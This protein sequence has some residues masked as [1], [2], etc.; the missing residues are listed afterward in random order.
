MVSTLSPL[1]FF[2]SLGLVGVQVYGSFPFVL[3]CSRFPCFSTA[4]LDLTLTSQVLTTRIQNA[5]NTKTM[6]ALHVSIHLYFTEQVIQ[7]LPICGFPLS[8]STRR[9]SCSGS[10]THEETSPSDYGCFNFPVK[11]LQ[12]FY[13]EQ[14]KFSS[15]PFPGTL[16]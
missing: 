16:K 14:K 3:V 5:L 10:V 8:A 6:E 12:G 15:N 1:I 11:I 2:A 9:E 13:K 7:C 4:V